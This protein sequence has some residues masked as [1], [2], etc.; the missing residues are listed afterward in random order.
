[1]LR[2]K[3]E[4]GEGTIPIPYDERE[5][6][7]DGILRGQRLRTMSCSDKVCRWNVLGLQ[8]GLLS[9]LIQPVY[10]SSL[11]L[12]YLFDHGHLSRALCCRL[13]KDD[14]LELPH[15]YQV[16]H[17]WLGR[18]TKY[19]VSRET[20]KTN[21]ISINWCAY[22]SGPEVTDGRIGAQLERAQYAP[23]VSRLCK[24][25]MFRRFR[26]ICAKVGNRGDL[27]ELE[28]YCEA[29]QA[30][31]DFQ[32]AKRNMMERFKKGKFGNWL[33]KPAEQDMSIGIPT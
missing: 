20:E 17:P 2:T 27:L 21:N 33:S 32:T 25:E 5:Q 1:M 24:R 7:M 19:D 30:A 13:E 26:E 23:A 12:G 11:T 3:I 31:S 8:G 6:T 4:D 28:T 10:L 15:P 14:K 18:I 9:N 29:K 22:D 16:H